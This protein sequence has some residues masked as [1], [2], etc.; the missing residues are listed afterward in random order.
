MKLP[1]LTE[2]SPE[3]R[4]LVLFDRAAPAKDMGS[5]FVL[6]PDGTVV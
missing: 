5:I 6:G 4:Q 2:L 3:M 1:A